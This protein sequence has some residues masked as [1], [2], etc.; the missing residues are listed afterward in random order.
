MFDVKTMPLGAVFFAPQADSIEISATLEKSIAGCSQKDH[1][2]WCDVCPHSFFGG[3]GEVE[4]RGG[5]DFLHEISWHDLDVLY[6]CF[7]E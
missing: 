7:Q 1:T 3:E 6:G 4:E 5:A 2:P